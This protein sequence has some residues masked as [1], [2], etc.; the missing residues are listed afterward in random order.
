MTTMLSH[1]EKVRLARKL[2]TREERMSHTPIFSSLA[3]GQRIGR[4]SRMVKQS[5]TKVTWWQRFL[6][7]FGLSATANK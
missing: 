6:A 1:T 7:L 3:W 4:S 5:V 2:L